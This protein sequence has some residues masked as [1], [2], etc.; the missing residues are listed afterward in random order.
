MN[1]EKI[2]VKD[3]DSSQEL[4]SYFNRLIE[5]LNG[6]T[7][8]NSLIKELESCKINKQKKTVNFNCQKLIVTQGVY[9]FE[10][11]SDKSSF[12]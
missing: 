12:H 11:I 8:Q 2:S 7:E 9:R 6:Q 5:I 1:R 10:Q 4:E 3:I